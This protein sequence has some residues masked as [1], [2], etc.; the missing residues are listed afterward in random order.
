MGS[1]T[2]RLEPTGPNYRTCISNTWLEWRPVW[3]ESAPSAKFVVSA[4]VNGRSYPIV[5]RQGRG[6]PDINFAHEPYASNIRDYTFTSTG[7]ILKVHIEISRNRPQAL[8]RKMPQSSADELATV[9]TTP[10]SSIRASCTGTAWEVKAEPNRWSE[11]FQVPAECAHKFPVEMWV[12]SKHSFTLYPMAFLTVRANNT[13]TRTYYMTHDNRT[14]DVGF[15]DFQPWPDGFK[16]S[17]LRV[18]SEIGQPIH[19][20]FVYSRRN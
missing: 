19:L 6:D 17:S 2:I 11:I 13:Q 14:T 1:Q 9:P 10:L 4:D 12:L 15:L 16:W 8:S 20:R 7:G 3:D 5:K 18:K